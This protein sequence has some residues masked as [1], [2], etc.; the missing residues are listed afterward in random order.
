MQSKT[1]IR[2]FN[3]SVKVQFS[4]ILILLAFIH[5][6]F[7]LTVSRWL[8]QLQISYKY[9]QRERIQNVP[10]KLCLLILPRKGLHSNSQLWGRPSM[11]VSG[12]LE[13][14]SNDLPT[15]RTFYQLGCWYPK[16]NCYIVSKDDGTMGVD[17]TML[18]W[19]SPN[20]TFYTSDSQDFGKKKLAQLTGRPVLYQPCPFSLKKEV[21]KSIGLEFRLAHFW[22]PFEASDFIQIQPE[23]EESEFY[24][25]EVVR[26]SWPIAL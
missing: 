8:P 5:H 1:V 13:C 12:T 7:P 26:A 2:A 22:I 9:P 16:P 21:V 18:A 20:F 14:I 11:T 10:W 3:N 25:Q 17:S 6:A 15:R 4:A 24:Y 23:L 19:N